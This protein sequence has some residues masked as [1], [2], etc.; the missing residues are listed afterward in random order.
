MKQS[1]LFILLVA[2][3]IGVNAQNKKSVALLESIEGQWEVNDEKQL[4]YQKV[5]EVPEAQ[6]S[7]LFERSTNFCNNDL[8]GEVIVNYPDSY[9]IEYSHIV[10]KVLNGFQEY[11]DYQCQVKFECK[12][13]KVRIT[14]IGVQI[15][16]FVNGRYN[17]TPFAKVYPI[18]EEAIMDKN[19]QV[20]WL[21]YSHEK[22][23]GLLSQIESYMKG[24]A[25]ENW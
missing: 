20:K 8:N 25:T 1:L 18:Y 19:K 14:L 10:E 5:I 4:L 21:Y 7:I 16:Q 2:L 12:E 22:S 23:L 9:T 13:E 6:K 3:A 11:A 17:H 15:N 24:P